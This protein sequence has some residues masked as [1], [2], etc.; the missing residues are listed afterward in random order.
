MSCFIVSDLAIG[1]YKQPVNLDNLFTFEPFQHDSTAI[2]KGRYQILFRRDEANTG[3]GAVFW[4]YKSEAD[5]D[6]DLTR[7]IATYTQTL[8]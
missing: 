1:P 8:K 4:K 3:P 7:L 5:R 2:E 6:C